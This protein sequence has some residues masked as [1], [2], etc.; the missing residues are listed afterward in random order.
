MYLEYEDFLFDCESRGLSPKTIKDYRNNTALFL[1]YVGNELEI[2]NIKD[3]KSIHVKHYLKS[4]SDSGCTNV[5]INSI[6]KVLRA[7]FA[8]CEQEEYIIVNPMKKVQFTREE[9]KTIEIFTDEEVSKML[10]VYDFS[11]YLNARNKAIL[12]VQLDTKLRGKGDSLWVEEV[13]IV[14]LRWQK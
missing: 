12:S 14:N 4:K 5:Y 10:N 8:Y 6:I 9:K 13:M 2:D 11:N 3:I 7:F 1:K